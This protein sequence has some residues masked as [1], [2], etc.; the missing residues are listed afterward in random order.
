[1]TTV[2]DLETM[3]T[4]ETIF[5]ALRRNCQR[6]NILTSLKG[7]LKNGLHCLHGLQSDGRSPSC[8]GGKDGLTNN[9][10]AM[11]VSSLTRLLTPKFWQPVA[12]SDWRRNT[13][14]ILFPHTLTL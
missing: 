6:K 3:E 12:T 4:M 10:S 9:F 5:Q 7:R 1:M 11:A 13:R 14:E 8:A 2:T